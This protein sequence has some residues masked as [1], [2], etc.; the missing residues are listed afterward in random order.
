MLQYLNA[1]SEEGN[2]YFILKPEV[3]QVKLCIIQIRMRR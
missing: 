1:L 2:G 3:F